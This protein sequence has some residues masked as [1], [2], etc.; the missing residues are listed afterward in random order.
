MRT[1]LRV[2][3]ALVLLLAAIGS[4]PAQETYKDVSRIARVNA[5]L[6]V[7]ILTYPPKSKITIQLK[8]SNPARVPVE[9]QA[10]CLDGSAFTLRRVSDQYIFKPGR[11]RRAEALTLAPAERFERQYQLHKLFRKLKTTGR[12]VLSWR[13]GEWRSGQEDLYVVTPYDPDTEKVAV[14]TTNLGVMEFVFMPLRAPEHVRNFVQLARHGYYD[15]L[16]FHRVIPG[17][18]AET[19]DRQGDGR[20]SWQQMLPPEVDPKLAPLKGMMGAMRRRET[21]MTSMTQVFILLGP[22]PGLRGR[23]TFFAYLRKGEEVLDALNQIPTSST[24]GYGAFRPLEP[25]RIESIEIRGE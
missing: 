17:L 6:L 5:E 18:Q 22:S 1:A 21:S 20:G 23:H 13:C 14:M 4:A 9:V 2:H 8:L 25:V 19:G 15:G 3:A 10:E 11:D 16:R 7:P 12:Y 24:K